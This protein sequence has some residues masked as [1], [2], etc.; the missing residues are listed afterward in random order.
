MGITVDSK[1]NNR[2]TQHLK[3]TGVV[4]LSIGPGS[5]ADTA[6][7]I[8]AVLTPEG[9]IIANDIIVAV[10]GKPMD[11]VEKLLNRIDNYKV[12][13]TIMLTVLRRGEKIEVPVTLQPGE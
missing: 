6:G 12:G 8:G 2:L 10:D 9:N 5:A 4:I 7:L 11:S 3:V 1:L 13:D